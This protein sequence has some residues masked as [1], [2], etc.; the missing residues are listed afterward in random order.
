MM[1]RAIALLIAAP[2][3]TQG[4]P[5]VA[6]EI[7]VTGGQREIVLGVKPVRETFLNYFYEKQID[8]SFAPNLN[9][10][11]QWVDSVRPG[12]WDV[13]NLGWMR[14]SVRNAELFNKPC[15]TIAS[16]S[17]VR[18]TFKGRR[19]DIK[20]ENLARQ[21]W[22]VSDEG[23]ILRHYYR[24]QTP[25]GVWVGDAVYGPESIEVN[26]TTPRGPSFKTFFPSC[27]MD[28][29]QE[30]FKP[31]LAGEEVL[32][33]VKS[34]PVF[35]PITGV[36]ENYEAKVSG[37]FH[38]QYMRVWFKGRHVEIKGPNKFWLRAYVTKEGDMIKVDFEN[39]KSWVISSLPDS[40]LDKDGRAITTKD[41]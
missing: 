19:N 38:S 12:G 37:T 28:A 17:L 5:K 11:G 40:K 23:R 1:L 9:S 27:G 7:P 18:Q 32:K 34:Y 36:I 16:D 30:Q 14:W 2:P 6:Y 25:E 3:L 24:L 21:Q 4:L 33:A 31:M 10:N 13:R 35:N 20:V 39:E 8:A 41:G 22:W 15:K 29:L 26:Q